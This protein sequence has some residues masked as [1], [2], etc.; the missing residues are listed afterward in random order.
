VIKT[1]EKP[2]RAR[3]VDAPDRPKTKFEIG[4][5]SNASGTNHFH[6]KSRILNSATRAGMSHAKIALVQILY[7]KVAAGKPRQNFGNDA[8]F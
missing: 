4:I 8:H 6:E 7:P 1:T 3:S 2:Q 5:S